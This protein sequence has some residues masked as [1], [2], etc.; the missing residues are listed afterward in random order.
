MTWPLAAQVG[1]AIPGDGF[2]GWQNFWNLWWVKKAL[3]E[4]QQN[5]FHTDYLFY[6][7][8]VDLYFH[9]LNIFNGLISLPIQGVGNL[10]WAYNFVVLLSF[11]LGGYGA[12]LLTRYVLARQGLAKGVAREWASFAGGCIFTFSPFHFAHLLGHMQVFSLEW[13]PFY[14]LAFLK[15]LG[16]AGNPLST[17]ARLRQAPPSLPG[18]GREGGREGGKSQGHRALPRAGLPALFLIL[19]GLCDWYY[20][21]YL[22]FFSLLALACLG[23]GRRLCWDHLITLASIGLLFGVIL[24]P[25][26]VPM[27]RTASQETFMVPDPAQAQALSADLLAFVTPSEFHPLWGKAAKRLAD[28]FTSTRSERTVFAGF[29]PL[30]LALVGARRGLRKA[31]LWWL[32]LATFAVLALGP[33]LHVGGRTGLGPGGMEIPLPYGVLHRAIPFMPITRSVSRFDVMVMLSLGVLAGVGLALLGRQRV[34]T[35]TKRPIA[36]GVLATALICFEF[37]PVP[38]PVSPPDT[39][40]WYQALAEEPGD[41]AIL[42]LPMNWDRPGYLLYQTV[43]GKRLTTAYISR[44]DPSTLAERLG[45]LQQFRHLGQDIIAQDLAEVAGT[46]FRHLNVRYLVA[47]LYKMPQGEERDRTLALLQK[48][49][50]PMARPAYVDERLIV[51]QAPLDRK[52]RPTLILGRGWG[53]LAPAGGLR[54]VDGK[55]ELF[56][57]AE[58][59]ASVQIKLTAYAPERCAVEAF[60]GEKSLGKWEANPTGES[61]ASNRFSLEPGLTTL[62]L[63]VTAQ[64]PCYLASLSLLE[65]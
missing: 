32:S 14:V 11:T 59:P 29:V 38:Y 8:G 60:L 22:G 30:A 35:G 45:I 53:R 40:N 65:H 31:G 62:N 34:R 7:T 27:I 28:H 19:V 49:M 63:H 21:M 16:P 6:P 25:L 57:L 18:S 13:I 24:S 48:V 3:L 43:H 50:G 36:V 20:V 26:L 44:D 10:Y 1:R 51:Y 58:Q 4:L 47:D 9:T 42:N 61:G 41:F 15:A 5:P 52:A 64:G 2:D 54:Q 39:P 23:V 55:A 12:Y 46:T 33:V 17:P 37:L 56:V